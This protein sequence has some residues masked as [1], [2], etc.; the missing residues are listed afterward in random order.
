MK[1]SFFLRKSRKT[2]FAIVYCRV[3]VGGVRCPDFSTYIKVLPENVSYKPFC[4][5]K[6]Q[7]DNQTIYHIVSS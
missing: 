7:A 6:S 4:I 5:H 2:A 1:V 3:S